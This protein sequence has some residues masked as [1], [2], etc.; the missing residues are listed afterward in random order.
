MA[1]SGNVNL[2]NMADIKDIEMADEEDSALRELVEKTKEG[3]I[4]RDE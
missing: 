1:G 4:K 3:G 2:T